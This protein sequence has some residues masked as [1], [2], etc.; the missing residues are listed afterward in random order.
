MEKLLLLPLLLLVMQLS[1]QS[2]NETAIRQ[3]LNEQIACWNRGD[4]ES[5]MKTYWQNDS[6]LFIGK[7]GITYGW[8]NTLKNYQKGYPD[9]A[10]MGKLSFTIL[11]TKRISAAYYHVTGKWHLQRSIGNLEGH[12]TLLFRKIK[13]KW[14][15]VA[16]HSS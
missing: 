12:F 13:R 3:S 7:S 9:T 4:L 1:A 16:D 10:A 6:L 15:I 8:K 11:H 2:K 5:F 14:L